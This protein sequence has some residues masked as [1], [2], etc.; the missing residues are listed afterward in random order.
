MEIFLYR[1][2]ENVVKVLRLR[3]NILFWMRVPREALT[4]ANTLLRNAILLIGTSRA[5]RVAGVITIMHA[6]VVQHQRVDSR[7]SGP[8]FS[9]ERSEAGGLAH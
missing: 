9:H 7:R 4:N 6:L 2:D 5:T 8:E 3:L 1:C